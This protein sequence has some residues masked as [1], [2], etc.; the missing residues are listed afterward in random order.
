MLSRER[1]EE[2]GFDAVKISFTSNKEMTIKNM[3]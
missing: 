1:I 2:K 3:R